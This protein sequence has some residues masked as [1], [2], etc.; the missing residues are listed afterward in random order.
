MRIC[1]VVHSW[2][3]GGLE[4]HVI[5]LCNALSHDHEVALVA[6]PAMAGRLHHRVHFMPVD[7]TRSRL[8]PLLWRELL[9]ALRSWPADI[10]HAQAN[11]SAELVGALRHWVRAG[12]FVATI[13][14]QKGTTR[15]YRHFD[16]VIAV[17]PGIVPLV[18]KLAPTTAIYNGIRPPD[19]V[20]NG[21]QW[22]ADTFRLDPA[23]PI[24][25]GLG[26]LVEAKGFD[27]LIAA[28]AIAHCQVV[29]AGDGPLRAELEAQQ[30]QTGGRVVFAGFRDDA[31]R[32]M[33]AADGFVLS[34]RNEGFAYVFVEA[35]LSER[36]V[37]ATHLPMVQGF[38]PEALQVPVADV[39]ALAAALTRATTDLDAWR[40]QMEPAFARAREELSLSSMVSRTEM[41]YRRALASHGRP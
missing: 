41:V 7:F 27:I 4:K 19:P 22:L 18:E 9:R 36:P 30:Q 37:I 35:L 11:K 8:S 12:A 32:L 38:V 20:R 6:H 15:M 10:V 40:E 17:S 24:L 26:R 33:A 14:N 2:G 29:I 16:Q 13:H 39:P 3:N 1:M 23:Q 31:Q 34:S 28:A 25:L 21:R 5:D